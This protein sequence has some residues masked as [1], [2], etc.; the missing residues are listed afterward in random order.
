MNDIYRDAERVISWLGETSDDSDLA[1]KMIQRWSSLSPSLWLNINTSTGLC[2]G[3]NLD[4]AFGEIAARA[5]NKLLERPYWTR[6]WIQQEV[7]LCPTVQMYC[8]AKC[9]PLEAFAKA[10]QIW[11]NIRISVLGTSNVIDNWKIL[12]APAPDVVTPLENMLLFRQQQQ[13]LL[14]NTR[15][16][17]SSDTS[18]FD[19][20][21]SCQLLKATDPRDKI[22]ALLGMYSPMAKYCSDIALDYTKSPCIVFCD[23]ARVIIKHE[24]SLRPV[25]LARNLTSTS[26]IASLPSWVPDW[27]GSESFFPMHMHKQE[28]STQAD[29]SKIASISENG[30]VL[31]LKGTVRGTITC[32]EPAWADQYEHQPEN[33]LELL[34]SKTLADGSSSLQAIFGL[35]SHHLRRWVVLSEE[36][37]DIYMIEV[38]VFLGII[39]PSDIP[40]MELAQEIKALSTI[41][42]GREHWDFQE[43]VDK[44]FLILK[45]VQDSST[46]KDGSA[47]RHQ[48]RIGL[49]FRFESVGT[50]RGR[51][52]FETQESLGLG[53]VGVAAGDIVFEPY[54]H[55]CFLIL[56]PVGDHFVLLGE[57]SIIAHQPNK[58][59]ELQ[60]VDIW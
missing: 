20:L 59:E 41:F 47:M 32:L 24:G 43:R 7:A 44:Y 31:S 10:C 5:V 30:L 3:S 21:R 50:V 54:G 16:A 36:Q 35:L 34:R 1:M 40:G 45:Y 15:P 38:M 49:S 14:S 18:L 60:T 33:L 19:V 4:E 22:Y 55:C 58:R 12:A 48:E 46:S 2:V 17:S 8:G 56:R 27:T 26:P 52:F 57:G 29:L 28:R 23:A 39:L 11:K 6:V 53:P 9:L 13:T 42:F 25:I 51:I 37:L